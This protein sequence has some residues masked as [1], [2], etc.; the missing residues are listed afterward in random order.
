MKRILILTADRCDDE[1]LMVP[2][3][4]FLEEEMQVTVASIRAEEIHAKYHF[5]LKADIS[6]EEI[7]EAD[8]DALYL[9]GGGAPEKLRVEPL[10]V[11][12]VRDFH[13][14][15]KPIGAICHGPQLMISADILRGRRATCYPGIADDVKNAGAIY[16]D[17]TTVTDGN[18]VTARRP[19]DLP[20]FLREFLRLVREM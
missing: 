13:T 8:Y 3:Y 12:A 6:L 2:Y 15:G 5:T 7:R 10:A 11:R 16:T 9:P 4:R 14:A 1:E 19:A 17:E 20:V 18:L